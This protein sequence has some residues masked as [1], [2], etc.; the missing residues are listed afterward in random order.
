MKRLFKLHNMDWVCSDGKRLVIELSEDDEDYQLQ[1]A[2]WYRR[3][4]DK[5]AQEILKKLGVS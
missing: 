1:N 3:P 4:T 5:E 2:E